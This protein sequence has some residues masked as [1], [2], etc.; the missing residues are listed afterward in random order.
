[1]LF[2][3]YCEHASHPRQALGTVLR[4]LFYL[5]KLL[6]TY[7]MQV[8]KTECSREDLLYIHIRTYR[9]M[10]VPFSGLLLQVRSR[11][12]A[13]IVA[14]HTEYMLVM[15]EV[16]GL[17]RC[18]EVCSIVLRSFLCIDTTWRRQYMYLYSKLS[19]LVDGASL[20]CCDLIACLYLKL[21]RGG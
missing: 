16:L 17:Y 13:G 9:S 5:V 15:A 19:K 10:P 7:A 11:C 12:E 14:V 3:L 1:M 20:V 6:V 2:N 4:T 21:S 18:V 8:P